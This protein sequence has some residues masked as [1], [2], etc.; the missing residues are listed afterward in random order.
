MMKMLTAIVL[1]IGG[2]LGAA[3]GISVD[4]SDCYR[5]VGYPEGRLS[6]AQKEQVFREF[7]DAEEKYNCENHKRLIASVACVGNAVR[8]MV[9]HPIAD[10]VRRVPDLLA[11]ATPYDRNVEKMLPFRIGNFYKILNICDDIGS[12][13]DEHLKRLYDLLQAD[14]SDRIPYRDE[15]LSQIVMATDFHK[16]A[17][18]IGLFLCRIDPQFES[19]LLKFK[20]PLFDKA[21]AQVKIALRD[22][23]M[24]DNYEYV[25]DTFTKICY[26]AFQKDCAFQEAHSELVKG[27]REYINRALGLYTDSSELFA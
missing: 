16:L 4:L 8:A 14:P 13:R 7:P 22:T 10:A 23:F 11:R 12:W 2:S 6:A 21:P 27:C 18:R 1:S 15:R 3:S 24:T 19:S 25:I 26:C 5:D 9:N 20:N 17:F